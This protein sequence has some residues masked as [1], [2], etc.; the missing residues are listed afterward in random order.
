MEKTMRKRRQSKAPRLRIPPIEELYGD[1]VGGRLMR[2]QFSHRKDIHEAIQRR[3]EKGVGYIDEKGYWVDGDKRWKVPYGVRAA[4]R[5]QLSYSQI[6]SQYPFYVQWQHPQRNGGPPRTL[7][8]SCM[9]LGVACAFITKNLTTVDGDAFIVS[10]LGF[11]IPIP[12]MGKFPRKLSDGKTYYWCPRCMQP[13]RFRVP[14]PMNP[15]TFYADKKFWNEEKG[16]YEWKNVKLA[17]LACSHCGISN[18]D[19]KFR[20]ANQPVEKVVIRPTRKRRRRR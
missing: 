12:L 8:R 20:S 15:T 17:Y 5:N 18:R 11:H 10:K 1:G 9:T 7:T 16:H 4:F 13:R 3:H 2:G 19:Q 14:D 6:A